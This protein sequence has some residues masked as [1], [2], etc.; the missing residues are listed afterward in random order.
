MAPGVAAGG[1]VSE[2]SIDCDGFLDRS[3]H[4]EC[5]KDATGAI[6]GTITGDSGSCTISGQ[7]CDYVIDCD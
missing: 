3:W 1:S 7:D 4:I 5:S 6:S 2:W